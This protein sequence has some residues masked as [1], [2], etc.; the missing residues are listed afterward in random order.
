MLRNKKGVFRTERFLVICAFILLVCVVYKLALFP[1]IYQ[2]KV[3]TAET[4]ELT[5]DLIGVSRMAGGSA[6]R[7]T[8]YYLD[9]SIHGNYQGG[10][11]HEQNVELHHVEGEDLALS[12]TCTTITS[13]CDV[14]SIVTAVI[15]GDLANLS[16]STSQTN[17]SSGAAAAGLMMR[18]R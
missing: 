17:S 8:Y 2:A 4:Y 16:T 7:S 13:I 6:M 10:K 12:L 3:L 14:D 11:I 1:A 9:Y 5:P 18:G 15:T